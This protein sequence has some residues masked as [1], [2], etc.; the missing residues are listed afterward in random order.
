[1]IARATSDAAKRVGVARRVFAN[2]LLLKGQPG[3]IG[4]KS[5]EYGES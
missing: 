4:L 3:S 5:G 2:V 1:V